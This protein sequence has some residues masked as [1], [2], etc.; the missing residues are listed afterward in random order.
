MHLPDTDGKECEGELTK[1]EGRAYTKAQKFRNSVVC[2]E[3]KVSSLFW[4]GYGMC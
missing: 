3:K 4:P 1:A 2:W